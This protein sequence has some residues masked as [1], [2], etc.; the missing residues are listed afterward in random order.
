MKSFRLHLL[1]LTCVVAALGACQLPSQGAQQANDLF[2][3]RLLLVPSPGQLNNTQALCAEG[4]EARD[5]AQQLVDDMNAAVANDR[6]LLEALAGAEAETNVASIKTYTVE[7]D[8]R[9]MTVEDVSNGESHAITASIDG[10][11]AFSATTT[12]EG[13]AGTLSYGDLSVAWDEEDGV[14]RAARDVAGEAPSSQAVHLEPD[15]VRIVSSSANGDVA[16]G[17]TAT[18]GVIVEGSAAAACWEGDEQCNVACND[19]LVAELQ[20]SLSDD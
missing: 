13:R 9:T 2:D 12:D 11:P 1:S 20:I 19:E 6:A 16:A 8:G 15:R 7:V 18:S 3:L 10:G 5:A 14:L 17:W 4:T